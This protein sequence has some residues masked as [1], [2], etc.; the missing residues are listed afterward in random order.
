[1]YKVMKSFIC[2]GCMNP[3]TS[4]AHTSVD[5][6]VSANLKLVDE[7]CYL[8]D[9]YYSKTDYIDMGMC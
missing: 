7:C 8:G 3:V 4:T 6:G 1:M 5:V 2:K 9:M